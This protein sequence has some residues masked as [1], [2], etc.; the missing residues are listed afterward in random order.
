MKC[1]FKHL[2]VLICHSTKL[3]IEDVLRESPSIK[4]I[5]MV[6][7]NYNLVKYYKEDSSK[8][9]QIKLETIKLATNKNSIIDIT[10]IL[11]LKKFVIHITG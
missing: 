10:S 9:F 4:E 5:N 8:E 2:N 7:Q 1:F 3:L 6:N 11:F